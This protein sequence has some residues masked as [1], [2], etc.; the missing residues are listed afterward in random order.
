MTPVTDIINETLTADELALLAE[1]AVSDAVAGGLWKYS[2][3]NPQILIQDLSAV[4]AES[5]LGYS[6]MPEFW[7][8]GFSKIKA[9]ELNPDNVVLP[10]EPPI[11]GSGAAIDIYQDGQLVVDDASAINFTGDVR[12]TGSEGTATITTPAPTF[13]IT[14]LSVSPSSIEIGQPL[15]SVQVSWSLSAQ[16]LEQSLNDAPLPVDSRNH[17]I[18]TVPSDLT[19]ILVASSEFGTDTETKTVQTLTR[20]YW[21][22][23]TATLNTLDDLVVEQSQLDANRQATLNFDANPTGDPEQAGYLYILYPV[24]H[25]QAVLKDT[26]G[27]DITSAFL[28]PAT[29]SVMNQ[30]DETLN[31]YVYRSANKLNGAYTVVVT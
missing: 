15:T 21:G 16:P 24:L 12:V 2:L 1:T 7:A 6:Q 18:S 25:G 26:N 31:Y 5:G 29:I 28:S 13:S 17:N 19:F 14:S 30:Y 27:I 3:Q 4:V 10:T 23:G 9:I 11:I 22:R 8:D 20:N